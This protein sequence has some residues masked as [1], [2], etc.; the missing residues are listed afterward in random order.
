LLCRRPQ[1]RAGA[2]CDSHQFGE[3]IG[4]GDAMR[5]CSYAVVYDTGFA[6]NPFGGFCTLA[7]C[8]PNHQG[9]RLT[10]G[11]WIVGH[12]TADQGHGLIYAM[13]IL[14]SPD[15]HSYYKD[16]RFRKK[17]PRFDLTWRQACGDN[18]YHRRGG[19]WV[20]SPTLFHR[21]PEDRANDTRHP[22]AFVAKRFFYFGEKAPAL[23]KRFR[24]LLR[25]RQGCKCA[26]P[27]KAVRDFIAWLSAEHSPGI[28]GKPRDLDWAEG[29]TNRWCDTR[30]LM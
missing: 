10:K 14:E 7:A 27:D 23:P 2:G 8:T 11:D 28:H 22:V 20:Q 18:I 19:K 12:A 30:S 1:Y 16:P 5:L 21:D 15:F 4:K 29:R 17:R 25:D 9:I 3:S 6:P 24:Q 13:E 26:H